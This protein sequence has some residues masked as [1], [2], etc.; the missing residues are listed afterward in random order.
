M[1]ANAKCLKPDQETESQRH[2]NRANQAYDEHALETALAEYQAAFQLCGSA[3]VLFGIA[4]SEAALGHDAA[5]ARDF[6]R[7]LDEAHDAEEELR[8]D[9]AGKLRELSAGLTVL[10]LGGAIDGGTVWVDGRAVDGWSGGMPIYLSPGG[11]TLRVEGGPAGP[12]ERVLTGTRGG[13]LRV[14]VPYAAAALPTV[15]Q[16]VAPVRRRWWLW[17]GIAGLLIAG[18]ITAG[19]VVSRTDQ[20]PC[21]FCP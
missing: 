16:P 19:Y 5:A 15:A 13:H 9:A 1:Q 14:E 17:A 18:A 12:F 3:M 20:P 4:H 2:L 21:A 7:F 8:K 11:H 6:G 10:D